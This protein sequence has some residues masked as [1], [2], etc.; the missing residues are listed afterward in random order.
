MTD[1]IKVGDLVETCSLMPGVVMTVNGDDITVRSL[2]YDNYPNPV[3][4]GHD[5]KYCGIVKIDAEGVKQRLIIGK[6]LLSKMHSE[7]LN[8]EEYHN[9]IKEYGKRK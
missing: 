3:F 1:Q 5:I 7:C 8:E 2:E 9:K 4:S 6:E